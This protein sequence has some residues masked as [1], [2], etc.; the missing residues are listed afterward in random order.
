MGIHIEIKP[1]SPFTIY[2]IPF[3]IISTGDNQTRR[4]ATAIGDYAVDLAVYAE[5]GCLDDLESPQPLKTIFL[6]V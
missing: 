4:C 2:N 5:L 3:G 1:T 6:R